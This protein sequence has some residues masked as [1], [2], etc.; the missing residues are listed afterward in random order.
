MEQFDFINLF[1]SK[2]NEKKP[3]WYVKGII[4][5]ENN[6]ITLGTDSKLIGRIFE[7]KSNSLLQ[8]IADEHEGYELKKP[9]TQ[10]EYPDFY[11]ECP[12]GK[13]IAI[14]IKTSYLDLNHPNKKKQ[15][16][17]IW[18]TLG[19]YKSYLQNGQ[20]NISGT[21]E[22]Y[23]LHYVIGFVYERLNDE[24]DG[25]VFP[26]S[27]ETIDTIGCP[28]ENV[29]VWVQEKYKITGFTEKSGNTTNIGSI[30]SR[31]IED[32]EKGNGPFSALDKL[33]CDDYWRNF[34]K[35]TK[36]RTLEDYFKWATDNSMLSVDFDEQEALYLNWRKRNR[37]N[38]EDL[39]LMATQVIH[40]KG[41]RGREKGLWAKFEKGTICVAQ[42]EPTIS[43]YILFCHENNID[44]IEEI[45]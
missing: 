29:R 12:D 35:G 14:D 23:K 13:R 3:N 11:F 26:F 24:D 31:S 21:Y 6:I 18:Y 28:Y 25:R 27:K 20:K 41:R 5:S 33:I 8:E 10:T 4:D 30:T 7:L 15:K 37:P 36:Y 32:F 22:D 44:V 2:I 19:S 45:M 17:D 40:A 38:R 9:E 39:L 1:L 43:K 42:K 16:E 34:K